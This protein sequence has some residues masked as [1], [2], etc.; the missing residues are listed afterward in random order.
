[1]NCRNCQRSLEHVFLDL[2]FSPPSNS[3]LNRDS[4]QKPEIYLPLKLYVCD[5]CWLVQ[6]EDY[7]S[8][9][10]FF[11][12]DYAYFSSVSQIWLEHAKKYTQMIIQRL[13][14]DSSSFVIEV[15]SNDGY[16]LRN[17]IAQNIP[18][19][20]I[21]PTR[22][23]ADAAE[24]LGITVLRKFFDETLASRLAEEDRKA[25][26]VIG[27]NVFA[28]V[29]NINDFTRGL[30]AVLKIGGTVTL[31]FPHLMRLLESVQFDT[32][33]HEH[34]SYLSLYSVCKIFTE[35]GLRVIDV[36][37]LPT[38]GGSIRIYGAHFDDTRETSQ[39]V[40]S[41]L[42]KERT[43]G[44][45]DLYT[46]RTFQKKVEALKDDFVLFLIKQ[47]QQGKKIAAYGAA[48]KGCTLLNFAGIKPDLIP[49]VC[50]ASPSKQGKFL[51][52]VHIPIVSPDII[53]ER[54]PDVVLI[55][56]WNIREEVI[57]QLAYVRQWGGVFVTA[58]P[59]IE[60]H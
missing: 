43:Q 5:N 59:R 28:H 42:D 57:Q 54:T 4:L 9:D 29:P 48:A 51:P 2:G 41:L 11:S 49:Y 18:C 24:L 38:H 55:L 3:Y 46:Y 32:V 19:L 44:M 14:L 23:T 27:N 10:T 56:P 1:M 12:A 39:A 33:Y 13:K 21:E 40:L 60:I 22:G 17:F 36:E 37:E 6:T 16:L 15:A 26:L 53:R 8:A 20:G 47:K 50:D 35:A 31:E 52:G 34:Y 58:V 30:K 25:D 45:R 7:A